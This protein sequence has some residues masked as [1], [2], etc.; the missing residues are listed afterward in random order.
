MRRNSPGSTIS[1]A[2]RRARNTPSL[3]GL[4]RNPTQ[5]IAFGFGAGLAPKAPGTVGSLVTV[6]LYLLLAPLPPAMYL[7]LLAALFALGVWATARAERALG[8]HDH[9]GIVWDEVV[10]Q[11]TALF[12]APVAPLWL[13]TG[14]VLFRLF[15]IWKPF[16][17]R[18]LNDRLTGGWGIMLDDLAAGI[19]AAA[20]LHGLVWLHGH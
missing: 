10:G 16:P 8:E 1:V 3:A 6:P 2:T 19:A 15:D 7:A 14:F 5:L 18:W 13:V 12:L 20:C 17:I 9:P 11:L 4:L